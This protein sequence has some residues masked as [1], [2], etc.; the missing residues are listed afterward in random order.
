MFCKLY[1][2]PLPNLL[3]T[4]FNFLACVEVDISSKKSHSRKNFQERPCNHIHD[5][6]YRPYL[7]RGTLNVSYQVIPYQEISMYRNYPNL[8]RTQFQI[9]FDSN[10]LTFKAPNLSAHLI[11]EK[12]K[13]EFNELFDYFSY[14]TIVHSLMSCANYFF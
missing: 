10:L 7:S 14:L 2:L 9:I 1:T 5:V 13:K 6:I 4:N 3:R 12:K 11:W 8:V